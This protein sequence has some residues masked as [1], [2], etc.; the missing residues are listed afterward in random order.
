[1][2]TGGGGGGGGAPS[3]PSL[4]PPPLYPS[5]AV[6][7]HIKYVME[8]VCH[9]M[10]FTDVTIVTVECTANSHVFFEKMLGGSLEYKF[11]KEILRH[12]Y[13]K[14]VFKYFELLLA[15]STLKFPKKV[16]L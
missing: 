1:L 7:L 9:S 15:N 2:E 3:F 4:L 5:P 11:Y 6:L 8:T 16:L 13:K 12:F 10:F 14:K